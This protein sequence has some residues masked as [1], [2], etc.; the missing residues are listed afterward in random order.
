VAAEE[1]VCKAKE[2]EVIEVKVEVESKLA[3]AEPILEAAKK[4]KMSMED[5][6][7]HTYRK[8]MT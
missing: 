6:L 7:G 2:I 4:A 5:V 1:K 8:T 3:E